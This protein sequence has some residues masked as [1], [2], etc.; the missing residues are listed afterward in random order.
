MFEKAQE[1][2]EMQHLWARQRFYH[3]VSAKLFLASYR[4]V[5]SSGISMDSTLFDDFGA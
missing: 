5:F 1:R 4:W 3:L 2:L